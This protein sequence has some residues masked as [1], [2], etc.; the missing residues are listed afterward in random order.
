MLLVL[1]L[2]IQID[3]AECKILLTDPPLNPSKNREKMVSSTSW[4]FKLLFHNLVFFL[5]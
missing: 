3:P 4:S 5:M 1:F 2:L